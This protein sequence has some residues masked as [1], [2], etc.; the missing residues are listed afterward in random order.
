[1]AVAAEPF[2]EAKQRIKAAGFEVICV[3]RVSVQ[4]A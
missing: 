2:A 4:P 1:M 3:R